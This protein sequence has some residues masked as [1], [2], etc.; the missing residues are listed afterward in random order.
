M[1]SRNA[2]WRETDCIIYSLV[3]RVDDHR[4]DGV[5]MLRL[6]RGPDGAME[7]FPASFS[8]FGYYSGIK[9]EN[10]EGN[11]ELRL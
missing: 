2:S 1:R 3:G 5:I 11:W 7:I 6:D 8:C 10:T 9:Y 4:L